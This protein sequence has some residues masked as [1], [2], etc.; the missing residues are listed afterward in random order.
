MT[1][2]LSHDIEILEMELQQGD[3]EVNQD[4]ATQEP[5]ALHSRTEA[6]V[7]NQVDKKIQIQEENV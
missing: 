2:E 3:E 4:V 1:P 5:T 7:D 6:P